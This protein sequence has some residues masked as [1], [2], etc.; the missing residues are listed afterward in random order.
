VKKKKMSCKKKK[1]RAKKKGCF[2]GCAK[3]KKCHAKKIFL[4]KFFAL[5][6]FLFPLFL[7]F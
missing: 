5:Q 2:I 1:C 3:K 6:V 7:S 4:Q